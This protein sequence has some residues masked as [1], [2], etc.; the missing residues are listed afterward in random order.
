MQ[1]QLTILDMQIYKIDGYSGANCLEANTVTTKW[2]LSTS[3]IHIIICFVCCLIAL[4]NATRLRRSALVSWREATSFAN[5]QI[6]LSF[7][8]VGISQ[9]LAAVEAVN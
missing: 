9:I 3:I 4:Y 6:M 5:L 8:L 7:L 2:W 1:S